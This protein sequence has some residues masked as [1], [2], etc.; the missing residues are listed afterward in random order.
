MSKPDTI[1]F[2]GTCLIDLMYPQAGVSA[3]QLIQREGV[4]VIFPQ[5]QRPV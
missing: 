1:Y 5:A 3:I 4:K 2:F